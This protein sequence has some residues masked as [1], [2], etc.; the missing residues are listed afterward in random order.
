MRYAP[1]WDTDVPKVGKQFPIR[2]PSGLQRI[3]PS[4]PGGS[5]DTSTCLAKYLFFQQ[6]R[7]EE[8]LS[9]ERKGVLPRKDRFCFGPT[10]SLKI[11]TQG[12][13]PADDVREG[14]GGIR[15]QPKPANTR[16]SSPRFGLIAHLV[17]K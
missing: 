2:R 4:Y 9:K 16:P 14:G 13:V 3:L 17:G 10:N 11:S 1:S 15:Q 7:K 5:Y 6:I 8:E 12:K